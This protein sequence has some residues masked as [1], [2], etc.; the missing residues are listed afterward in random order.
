MKTL[1]GNIIVFRLQAICFQIQYEVTQ[2]YAANAIIYNSC[3][4][5]T[6]QHTQVDDDNTLTKKTVLRSGEILTE[7]KKGE[8]FA[9]GIWWKLYMSPE[10]Y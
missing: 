9:K 5:C 10:E 8:F 3:P 1:T 4:C 7:V 2:L 6:V